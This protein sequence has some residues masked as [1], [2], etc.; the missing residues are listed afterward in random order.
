MNSTSSTEPA[1][2]NAPAR[3]GAWQFFLTASLIAA[4]VAVWMSP[5]SPPIVLVFL[6]LGVVA[7]GACAVALH[8]VLTALA[9]SKAHE[10][11]VTASQREALERD[12]L[13]TLRAIKDLEFDKAMGKISAA[14]A[15]PMERRLRD[16]AMAIMQQLD[17]RA[18]LRT[19]IERDFAARQATGDRPQ[20]TGLETELP[21]SG[22]VRCSSCST[23][24]DRDAKFC[25]ECGAKL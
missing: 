2:A 5:P 21:T 12:K 13:L 19:Q 11:P 3:V 24:N 25:K 14:D 6:S 18:V 9:G 22:P 4:A 8:G 1:F 7:A 23:A 20:A 15:E 10:A 16:R 17:G